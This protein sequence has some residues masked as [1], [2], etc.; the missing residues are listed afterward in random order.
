MNWKCRVK[1]FE[2]LFHYLPGAT[3]QNHGSPHR[4][5]RSSGRDLIQG[6]IEYKR[7]RERDR[8]RPV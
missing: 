6:L 8:E 7:E 3:E 5:S 4:D 1:E 2:E